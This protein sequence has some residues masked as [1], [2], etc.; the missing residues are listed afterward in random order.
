[1]RALHVARLASSMCCPC[2]GSP[3]VHPVVV[4]YYFGCVAR[5]AVSPNACVAAAQLTPAT[6]GGVGSSDSICTTQPYKHISACCASGLVCRRFATA[7]WRHTGS[8]WCGLRV[9]S[10]F[11][12]STGTV[13]VALLVHVPLCV[14][15]CDIHSY[16]PCI[17]WSASSCAVNHPPWPCL[18]PLYPQATATLRPIV[19]SAAA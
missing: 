13:S 6:T 16:N 2:F 5:R 11:R 10:G 7:V 17:V 4:W 12:L 1:M 15:R 19:Y 18:G 9:C 3:R 8:C 14:C